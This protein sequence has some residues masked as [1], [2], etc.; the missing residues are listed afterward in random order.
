MPRTGPAPQ[1]AGPFSC[2]VPGHARDDAPDWAGL[3]PGPLVMGIL[4]ATPD[5]FS[6]GGDT[7]DRSRAIAAGERMLA[8]GAAIVDVGGESTR[9]GAMPV[10]PAMEQAR[11]LP[12]VEALARMGAVVSVD[13]RNASTMARALDAGARVVN[14]VSGLA[15]DPEALPLVA[16][17]GCPVVLM[18]MRGTPETMK[19]LAV[20]GDV[21]AEVVAEIA[22]RRDLAVAAG[23]KRG[24]ILLDPGFGFAKTAEQNL[25]LLRRLPGLLGLGHAI[26]VGI[27]RKATIGMLSGETDARRR[28]P[29]SIAAG[30]FAL[31]RG[32][33]VLRVHD[34]AETVQAVRVW[35]GLQG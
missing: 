2:P 34:V 29:G 20:Y 5:S 26:C 1:G 11:V 33:R 6:D 15:H 23:V 3:G 4:N 14:D 28:G 12:V 16:A 9:P 17:R 13:T 24:D 8:D 30:L 27:S 25:E 19:A 35:R 7:L 18:H 10:H 32:A 22:A 31:D 21:L